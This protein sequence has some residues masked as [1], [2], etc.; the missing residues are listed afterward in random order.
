M[1][2]VRV[3]LLAGR[4]EDQKAALAKAITDAMVAHVNAKPEGTFIV[5]EDVPKENWAVAG[6]LF[7]RR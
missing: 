5:F 4:S 7:S 3:E 1:P 6:T 2:Y